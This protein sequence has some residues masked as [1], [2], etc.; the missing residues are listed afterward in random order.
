M[1]TF[2]HFDSCELRVE[3]ENEN[4]WSWSERKQKLSSN[5]SWNISIKRM[6]VPSDIL[7]QN[8]SELQQDFLL[9]YTWKT[10]LDKKSKQ[11]WLNLTDTTS[12]QALHVCFSHPRIRQ[13]AASVER[14]QQ[15]EA[16]VFGH[17][18]ELILVPLHVLTSLFQHHS[19]GVS[20]QK[21]P[22]HRQVCFRNQA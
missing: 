9:S 13:S 21:T 18:Q 3:A 14:W 8:L 1:P 5:H 11:C 2:K 22:E 4:M 17:V 7:L 10:N 20:S 16:Q 15:S 12:P 19:H 6:N